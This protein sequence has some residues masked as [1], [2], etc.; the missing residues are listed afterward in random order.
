ML[1]HELLRN[2]PF[3]EES[4]IS[5]PEPVGR[6]R[7]ILRVLKSKKPFK[8]SEQQQHQDFVNRIYEKFEYLSE[9]KTPDFMSL[10]SINTANNP[11][12]I[13]DFPP[14]IFVRVKETDYEKAMDK[15]SDELMTLAIRFETAGVRY[16]PSGGI[17]VVQ[18]DNFYKLT[19]LL[20]KLPTFQADSI[21]KQAG[22]SMD[23]LAKEAL[24]HLGAVNCLHQDGY[25]D[26]GDGRGLC[27]NNCG[28]PI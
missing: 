20:W 21:L 17:V 10:D 13:P 7:Y 8:V 12:Y 23:K 14:F 25:S 1:N 18:H 15:M 5:R 16:S 3:F 28:Q 2:E 6:L 24:K 9:N 11:G 26:K 4:L 27:C 19:L 22:S